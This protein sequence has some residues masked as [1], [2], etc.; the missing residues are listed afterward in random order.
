MPMYFPAWDTD[1]E[2]NESNIKTWLD[3]FYGK[4]EP[5]EQARWNQSNIDTL[6]YAGEQRFIN[7]YFNFYPQYNSQTFAFN[8][9]QQPVNMITGYQR[10]HRKS[11]N[12][13]PIE[14]SDQQDADDLTKLVTYANNYRNILEKISTAYEQSAIAG[15]VLIQPYLDYTDDPITGTMD[16]RVWSYN[17]FMTDSYWKQPDMSDCNTVWCQQYVSKAE[18]KKYFR[19]KSALIDTMSGMGNRNGKF[20]FLPENYNLARNDLLVLSY[21]WF[22]SKRIKK[23][24]YHR[25][26]G[27]AY[28]YMEKDEQ[29]MSMIMGDVS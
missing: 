26:N 24:L 2:P 8:L 4:F 16:V 15:M 20:Y 7:S 5:L 1:N 6:F 17:E 21:V 28:E 14:G 22:Q 29:M 25:E 9:I 11:V 23:M 19:S 10:Q 18:A 27:I 12:Y 13:T 3:N